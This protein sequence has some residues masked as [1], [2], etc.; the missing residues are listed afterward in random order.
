MIPKDRRCTKCGSAKTWMRN[1]GGRMQPCWHRHGSDFLCSICYDRIRNKTAERKNRDR[2]KRQRIRK[3]L[4]T[5]VGRGQIKCV[6]CGCDNIYINSKHKNPLCRVVPVLKDEK[7]QVV[8]S[9]DK[10]KYRDLLLDAAETGLGYFGFDADVY[11]ESEKR[12]IRSKLKK[13]WYELMEEKEEKMWE[14]KD[15][16]TKDHDQRQRTTRTMSG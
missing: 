8:T 13:W 2:A 9:Y 12:G 1:L 16:A 10:E 15:T 4:L 6:H 14:L 7:E 11:K 3:K 5:Y